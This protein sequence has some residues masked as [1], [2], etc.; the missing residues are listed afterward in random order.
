MQATHQLNDPWLLAV[1][2]GMSGVAISAGYYLLAKLGMHLLVDL[3]T[4]EFFEPAQVDV[5]A[6]LIAPAKLPRSR[7]FLWNDPSNHHDL[8][9]FLGEAQPT[10]KSSAFCHLLIDQ[11][12]ALGVSH[13]LTFAAL[14][15]Q[16]RPSH[17]CRVYA[18]ATNQESLTRCQLHGL[19][20]LEHGSI[21]GLNGTLLSIAASTGM[22]GTCILGE[23][24]HLFSHLPFPK[25]SLAVLKAF[26]ALRTMN[27]DLRELKSHAKTVESSL[28]DFLTRMEHAVENAPEIRRPKSPTQQ[29]LPEQPAPTK[30]PDIERLFAASHQ[31]RAHAYELKQLL[32]QLGVFHEYE[33]RFLDL[34]KDDTTEN[35]R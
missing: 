8:L 28:E 2:P 35:P 30:H 24:P 26:S 13:V 18:A 9:L 29:N 22:P 12:R 20:P 33:D 32:D 21:S 10:S 27:I 34:F 1:W 3:P 25:A 14:A 5:H 6:G 15:S 16:M 23:I 4:A 11:A 7:L 31:D 17:P 19:I